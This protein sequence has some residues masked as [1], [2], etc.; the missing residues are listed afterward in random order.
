MTSKRLSG[1]TMIIVS[2]QDWDDLH[3]RKQRF[4][5]R[6]ADAG[7]R[8]LY[9]EAQWHWLTYLRQ[10]SRARFRLKLAGAA[11]RAIDT[12]LWLWTPPPAIPFFQIWESLARFNNQRLAPALQTALTSMGCDKPPL[13]YLYTPYNALLIDTPKTGTHI[14]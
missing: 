14:V 4:A 12:N 8:V 13:L 5:R 10:R 6:F 7:C 2:T 3:T 9:V 11:P 1:R